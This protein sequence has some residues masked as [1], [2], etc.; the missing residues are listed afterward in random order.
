MPE[1]K[2]ADATHFDVGKK[3]R[4]TIEEIGGTMPEELPAEEHIIDLVKRKV[5]Q[6]P[7]NKSRRKLK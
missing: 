5:G 6:L 4:G 1:S 2:T 7:K 3:V